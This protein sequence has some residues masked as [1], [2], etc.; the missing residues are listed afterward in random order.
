MSTPRLPKVTEALRRQWANQRSQMVEERTRDQS[1]RARS[2]MDV[3][4]VDVYVKVMDFLLALPLGTRFDTR[5]IQDE[6]RESI[7][8]TSPR[9]ATDAAARLST[10][11]PGTIRGEASQTTTYDA[12]MQAFAGD[13]WAIKASAFSD[14]TE[15]W[16]Y[17]GEM[18]Q[19]P[20]FA[21]CLW[22]VSEVRRKTSGMVWGPASDD[23]QA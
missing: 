4:I 9:A 12:E 23:P 15:A 17:V 21:S 14:E 13:L 18:R 20:A 1:G 10:T 19:K 16:A 5:T 22:R 3:A 11:V 7:H 6:I 2:N 8:S